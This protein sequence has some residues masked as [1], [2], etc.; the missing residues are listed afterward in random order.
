MTVQRGPAE[1]P[2]Q[3]TV[4]TPH[5]VTDSTP[6]PDLKTRHALGAHLLFWSILVLGTGADLLSK[7]LVFAS[8]QQSP[9]GR[10]ILIRGFLHFVRDTNTGGPFSIFSGNPGWLALATFVALLIIGTLYINSVHTR[11]WLM[12]VALSLVAAGACGNLVD[13]LL[14]AHVRDFIQFWIGNWPYPTFNVAD[15]LIC[16]GAGLILLALI[17]P[18]H[19][20]PASQPDL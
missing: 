13:R 18:A 4:G 1:V 6:P 17:R 16:V 12:L 8:L 15:I 2:D 10:K 14:Y 11:Q 5:A 7:F 20:A 19:R 9:A 3:G